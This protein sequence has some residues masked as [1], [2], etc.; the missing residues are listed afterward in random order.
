MDAY[1]RDRRK[2]D[3]SRGDML[4]DGTPNNADRVEIGPTLLAYREWEEAGLE[5]P[6]LPAMRAFRWQRLVAG[7]KQKF[8][9]E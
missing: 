5:L 6:D 8:R 9:W 4:G 3:P 7:V 1:F 2:I